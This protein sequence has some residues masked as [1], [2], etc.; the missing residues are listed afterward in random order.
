MEVGTAVWIRDAAEVWRAGEVLA[1]GVG[2]GE[3][4]VS[5]TVRP[6]DGGADVAVRAPSSGAG[7]GGA[8]APPPR[9]PASAGARA[10]AAAPA[11]AA[12]TP[13]VLQRNVFSPGDGFENVDDLIGLPHLHEPA[14]L[15]VRSERRRSC[16]RTSWCDAK[17]VRS[18][19]S[20]R[21]DPTERGK[22]PPP[23]AP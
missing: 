6:L 16:D 1:R 22:P 8:T 19:S 11:A 9:P 21:R 17:N 23:A 3:A 14:I 2:N 20:P 12:A 13:D 7:A 5:L 4:A 18:R 15:E 10:A